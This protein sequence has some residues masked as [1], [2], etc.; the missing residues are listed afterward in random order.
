MKRRRTGSG[1]GDQSLDRAIPDLSCLSPSSVVQNSRDD[2]ME[3]GDATLSLAVWLVALVQVAC[4]HSFSEIWAIQDSRPLSQAPNQGVVAKAWQQQERARQ[5]RVQKSQRVLSQDSFAVAT[6]FACRL[7]FMISILHPHLSSRAR[8]HHC[9]PEAARQ[10][11]LFN[12]STAPTTIPSMNR[13]H[14][15][16]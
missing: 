10:Q 2:L 13:A 15:S 6:F 14:E 5:H 11:M 16:Y 1:P 9:R 4:R 3:K 8:Q 12:T 7:Q